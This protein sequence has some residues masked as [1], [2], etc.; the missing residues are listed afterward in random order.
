MNTF[1]KKYQEVQLKKLYKKKMYPGVKK[2]S[3]G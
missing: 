2:A 1:C 3:V